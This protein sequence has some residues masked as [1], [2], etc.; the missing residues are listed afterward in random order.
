MWKK[1]TKYGECI[2]KAI[3]EPNGSEKKVMTKAELREELCR[4]TKEPSINHNLSTFSIFHRTHGNSQTF[5]QTLIRRSHT[6]THTPTDKQNNLS[7]SIY[8]FLSS[9]TSLSRWALQNDSIK[10]MFKHG[11]WHRN[12]NAIHLDRQ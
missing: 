4:D 6:H 9:T 5:H 3:I 8:P 12:D 2:K 10:L 11:Y 7:N 1:V